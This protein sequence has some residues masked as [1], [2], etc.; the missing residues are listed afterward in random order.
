MSMAS[1]RYRAVTA[2]GAITTGT[3]EAATEADAIAQIRG[4]G[5]LPLAASRAGESHWRRF[6]PTRSNAKPSAGTIAFAIQELAALLGAR[7]PL[8][9]ALAILAELEET[10]RLR[11]PL[12]ATLAAVRDGANL[13][14]ALEASGAFSK[15][16]VTM[17]RAGEHGGNLEATLKRLS[18]YLTRA[19]A[20]RDAVISAMIYPAVLLAM[21]ALSGL[22]VVTYVLP[23]FAPLFEQSGRPLPAATAAALA[24]GQ[25]LDAWWWLLGVVALAGVLVLRRAMAMPAFRAGRDRIALRLPLVGD[26]LLK[27]QIERFSRMLGALLANGVALPQALLLARDTLTN[28]VVADAIGET[29]MRLKEGEGLAARLRQTGVFPPLMLDLV[30]VGE[31]T[32]TLDDML[33]K[34]ADL[35]EHEVKHSVDRLLALLVPAM[36]VLMGLVVA[37]LIGSILVAILSINDLAT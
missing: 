16:A 23:E 2:A 15:S 5:H 28:A 27:M 25:F 20:V 8:D 30:R 4:R 26:L 21:G 29:A 1:F 10:R 6:L 11:A 33:Q 13:S 22:F 17:V 32:G 37:G 7:L 24:L 3:L 18:D 31:E 34:Q 9:R 19:S 12:L 36:T 14:D 35:Y